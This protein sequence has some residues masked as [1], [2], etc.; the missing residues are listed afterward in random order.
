MNR[1]F[2]YF[3]AQTN[4][5]LNI[6]LV[7]GKHYKNSDIEWI[8][9]A[10]YFCLN[11]VYN[12]YRGSGKP[13]LAHLVGTASILAAQK[14]ELSVVISALMHAIYQRRVPFPEAAD[15]SERRKIVS[16]LFGAE[17]ESLIFNYTEYEN[18]SFDTLLHEKERNPVFYKVLLMRL[19][20]ELED[21]SY[22]SIF[23]HGKAG[24]DINIKGS[25]LWR[26]ANK[27]EEVEKILVLLKSLG[28]KEYA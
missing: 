24:D 5:E 22:F 1:N 21:L 12:I 13:F 18:S 26:Q 9:K 16:E 28:I 27:S 11:K 23:M 19:A 2:L 10:Y 25:F 8:N 15:L 6:Q 20:D 14:A 7:T 3:P 4:L 17:V